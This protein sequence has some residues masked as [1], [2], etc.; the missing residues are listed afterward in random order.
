VGQIAEKKL[1]NQVV[2]SSN[3][4]HEYSKLLCDRDTIE[5]TYDSNHSLHNLEFRFN[6]HLNSWDSQW[7]Q[8]IRRAAK[9]P[10]EIR[11][12]LDLNKD[13]D[14]AAV[15]RRKIPQV[16]FS[17]ESR[18][19]KLHVLNLTPKVVPNLLSWIGKQQSELFLMYEYLKTVPALIEGAAVAT[20][21]SRKRKA[22]S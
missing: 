9:T 19:Q 14:K 5:S 15:A 13:S 8:R 21:A 17:G 3:F 12:L 4:W 1:Y 18:V 16:H 10:L 7:D 22:Q 11:L 6:V 20:S 2:A